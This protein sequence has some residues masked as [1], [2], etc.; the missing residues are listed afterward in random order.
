MEFL[1]L[2]AIALGAWIFYYNK[3]H[4]ADEA[5]RHKQSIDAANERRERSRIEQENAR[6]IKE[7]IE[8]QRREKEAE[9]NNEYR[10]THV[11]DEAYQLAKQRAQFDP[12]AVSITVKETDKINTSPAPVVQKSAEPDFEDLFVEY[13]SS[14]LPKGLKRSDG[15]A[16][17]DLISRLYPS[18]KG[19]YPHE[20]LLLHYAKTFT[21]GQ[22]K[23]QNFWYYRYLIPNV[24]AVLHSLLD[25]GFL[26]LEGLEDRLNSHTLKELKPLLEKKGLKT[27][28]R[29]ADIV[30]MI[31]DNYEFHEIP[32]KF[33]SDKNA[34]YVLTEIG[35]NEL[36][37]N[38]YVIFAHKNA[39]VSLEKLNH[40][41]VK[42]KRDYMRA[43]KES[44]KQKAE[45]S[46]K[47]KWRY[48][49]YWVKRY[50]EVC[51]DAGDF[52]EGMRYL[53][54]SIALDLNIINSHKD[55]YSQRA[56]DLMSALRN[57]F[58]YERNSLGSMSDSLISLTEQYLTGSKLDESTFKKA[59]LS[60]FV[61]L[62]ADGDIFSPEQLTDVVFME[63]H[64]DTDSLERL[65][66]VIKS[67]VQKQLD[68]M[69]REQA[70][71]RA[72]FQDKYED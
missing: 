30:R 60:H 6:R 39:S 41:V 8:Q 71:V 59:I 18:D 5:I 69:P 24:Q 50:A 62:K 10:Y 20:I 1:I 3:K 52:E 35:R 55:Y 57:Y 61:E 21:Y 34:H 4:G 26:D 67:E 54:A 58:P 68:A 37:N 56:Y 33:A 36:I 22:K 53:C 31:I 12:V 45:Q 23:Y 42:E 19:L 40:V 9:R 28:R 14:D 11:S 65:Y 16:L 27:S 63:L 17:K 15:S 46:I 72:M 2:L 29:K 43:V 49:R 13:S 7:S 48:N 51:A 70:Y 64:D 32:K 47:N 66:E 44:L 38:Q 25:R